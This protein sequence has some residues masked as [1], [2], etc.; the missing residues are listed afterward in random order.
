MRKRS[1]C[2]ILSVLVLWTG[3]VCVAGQT[4]P[5]ARAEWDRLKSVRDSLVQER[6]RLSADVDVISSHIDSLKTSTEL[7]RATGP[8]EAALR[9]SLGLVE[10][11]EMLDRRLETV[12]EGL[13]AASQR[14]RSEYDGEIARLVQRLGEAPGEATLHRLAELREKRNAVPRFPD[15]P[16]G[17]APADL[18]SI[19][20]ADGPGEIRQKADL[21]DDMASRLALEARAVGDRLS[22][23]DEE[24]RLR[25]RVSNFTREISLFDENLPVGRSVSARES[26]P[27]SEGDSKDTGDANE[28]LTG[29]GRYEGDLSGALAPE[30]P[31]E[32]ELIAGKEISP[33]G[34]GTSPGDL[35]ADDLQDEIA[36]LRSRNTQLRSRMVA[37]T[38]QAAAFRERIREMLEGGR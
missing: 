1:F 20:E 25:A 32:A 5:E 34:S 37:L 24:R 21:M 36:R 9:R 15:S 28:I 35:P 26:P 3:V 27:A 22:R 31:L 11:L 16:R 19:G 8:L 30:A 4:L 2:L 23:L 14:L 13:Q 7:P 29:G 6:Q 18:L 10:R 17:A 12:H 38:K 33:G